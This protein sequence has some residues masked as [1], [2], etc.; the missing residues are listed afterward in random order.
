MRK[1]DYLTLAHTLRADIAELHKQRD[2]QL[3]HGLKPEVTG[4]AL[5]ATMVATKALEQRISYIKLLAHGLS[6]KLA[7]DRKAFLHECGIYSGSVFE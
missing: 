7:V 1:Q 2:A 3:L 5:D 6:M 4:E